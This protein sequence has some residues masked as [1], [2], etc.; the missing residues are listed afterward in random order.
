[1]SRI[2]I[3]SPSLSTGDAVSNDVLGMHDVLN[4]QAHDVRVF[5]ET[6]NLK[7]QAVFDSS[8]LRRFLRSADDLLIYHHARGWSPALALLRELPCRKVIKYHN[9]TPAHFFAGF[10]S[11]DEGLC[12][13]GRTE[14]EAVAK[15][16]CDL[17][18]S[19]SAFNMS[20]LVSMGAEPSKCFVVPP[21]HHT[22]RLAGLTADGSVLEKYADGKANVLTVGRVVPNKGHLA[23]LEAFA[24]FHFN[25]NRDSRLLIVG[26]GGDG[27]TP[28]SKLLHRAVRAFGLTGAVVFSGEVS[29]QALRAYYEVA[30]AFLM[31]SEHEGFCV[32]LVEAMAMNV[33]IV[34]YAS[35]AI[36]ETI[37]PAG[38][39][40]NERNPYLL[41]E[42]INSIVTER[43]LG[44]NLSAIG[45]RRYQESFSNDQ[46]GAR[47]LSALSNLP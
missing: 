42:S 37:G 10:S 19:D 24:T 23:L 20:E 36:P 2:G 40:W 38:V 31:T 32:P 25:C 33:P 1:M 43:S 35:S 11:S 44:K 6:H 39:V 14:L 47:F 4:R 5:T 26:K 22:D 17:Y 13:T 21:F 30:D 27:L 46:I 8:K 16:D 28:Y 34:A 18:L 45:R 7:H 9:I 15:Y 12:K 29:D 41:A 3:L